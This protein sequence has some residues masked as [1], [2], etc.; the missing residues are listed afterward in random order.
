MRTFAGL[1]IS[2]SFATSPA[3][4]TADSFNSVNRE[5]GA[6]YAD[7]GWSYGPGSEERNAK[8]VLAK[9]RALCGSSHHYDQYYCERGMKVF[10]KAHAEYLARQART[11]AV[12]P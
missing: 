12:A 2:F 8:A 4:A 7:M 3:L 10:R 5:V 6:S 11:G 1:L 9:L